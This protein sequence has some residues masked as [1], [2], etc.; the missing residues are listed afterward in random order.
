MTLSFRLSTKKEKRDVA[1]KYAYSLVYG[2]TKFFLEKN[3]IKWNQITLLIV[4]DIV[5]L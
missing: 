4:I 3:K 5:R 2:R 1:V